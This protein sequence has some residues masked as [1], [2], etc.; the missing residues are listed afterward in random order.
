MVRI[1]RIKRNARNVRVVRDA[2]NIGIKRNARIV[3]DVRMV[4]MC[5]EW[6]KEKGIEEPNPSIPFSTIFVSAI[7]I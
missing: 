1:M 2:R 4:R 6:E 3:R 5:C 7:L